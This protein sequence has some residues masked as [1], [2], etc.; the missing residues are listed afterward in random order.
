MLFGGQVYSVL[1]V[2]Q[3]EKMTT[4]LRSILPESHYE[5]ILCVQS[6]DS[7]RRAMLDRS[8]DIV[9]V[10]SPLSDDYG[11]AAALDASSRDGSVAMLIVKNEDFE[12]IYERVV[13]F[14]VYVLPKPISMQTASLALKWGCATRERL[15]RIG[16]KSK[17]LD[18]KMAEIRTVNKAKWLLI[19]NLKMTESEA[20]RYIEKQAMDT[21]APK[22]EIANNIIKT[23][24]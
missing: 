12:Q 9:I 20:H 5:P 8:F 13:D 11:T 19:T 3:S 16:A 21:C 23:Y 1:I 7:A 14:G 6:A 24:S 4:S 2:S 15:R 10:N 18:E 17:S 22:T